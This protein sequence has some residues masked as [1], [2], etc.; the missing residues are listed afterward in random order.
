[1]T[2]PDIELA[3]MDYLD[4]LGYTVTATP[5]DLQ[6]HLPCIRIA[7][8]SGADDA[9]DNLDYPNVAVQVYV[10]KSAADPRAGHNL[11][12]TIR[13]RMNLIADGGVYVTSE[14][15]LM[16]DCAT[17]SGP[18]ELTYIDPAI[19]VFQTVHRVTTKGR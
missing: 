9:R 8:L 14:N 7:R 6:D 13:N 5:L 16:V 15:A 2:F 19:S 17:I 11:S 10:A 12:E 3:L 1:M 4:D 18:A